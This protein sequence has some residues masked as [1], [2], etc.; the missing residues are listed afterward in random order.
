MYN[1]MGVA[2]NY[3][4]Y[5]GAFRFTWKPFILTK[6]VFVVLFNNGLEMYIKKVDFSSINYLLFISNFSYAWKL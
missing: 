5:Y 4:F 1:L 3:L 2:S 6:S